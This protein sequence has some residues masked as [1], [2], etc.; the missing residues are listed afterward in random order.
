MP[1]PQ[2]HKPTDPIA[3]D[4]HALSGPVAT[5]PPFRIPELNEVK[6]RRPV[7]RRLKRLFGLDR[8]SDEVQVTVFGPPEVVPGQT[9]RLMVN[10]HRPDAADS[11]HTLARAIQ[12]DAELLGSGPVLCYVDREAELATHV[13][14]AGAG[15]AKSLLTFTWRGQPRRLLF[16]LHIPWEAAAGP[17]AGVVSVGYNKVR[18]AK[19]EISL[20]VLR[21]KG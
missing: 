3:G 21:R 10:L 12:S 8:A 20:T 4:P 5:A 2:P 6:R 16:D 18:V 9:A 1:V 19:V 14:V 15:V 7:S 13:A 11:V 17:A